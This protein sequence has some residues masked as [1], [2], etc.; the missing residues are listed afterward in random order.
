MNRYPEVDPYEVLGLSRGC[1]AAEIKAA[2]KK[3]AL[4]NH[5]DRAP[6][7]AKDEATAC[8]KRIGEAYTYLSDER[9]RRDYDAFGPGGSGSRSDG[10]EWH[11]DLS[12]KH[13]GTSPEGVPFSFTWES[14]ADSARRARF[15]RNAGRPFGADAFE[16]FEL[17]N[18]MF[19]HEFRSSDPFNSSGLGGGTS[20]RGANID[21]FFQN[22]RMMADTMGFG[23]GAPPP[24]PPHHHHHGHHHSHHHHHHHPGPPHHM[25]GM[26]SSFMTSSSSS[27]NTTSSSSQFGLNGF[28]S[29]S[30]ST[31]TRI[32]NGRQETVTRQV[33]E[34]GNETIHTVSPEGQSV[35]VNGVQQ[36]QHPL[37]GHGVAQAPPA[38]PP[39]PVQMQYQGMGTAQDPIVLDS[40]G[41]QPAA[42]P[43]PT[44]PEPKKTTFGFL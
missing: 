40:D 43:T 24:P 16:P 31:T 36:T 28:S 41:Q 30:Q 33:D 7:D 44:N 20:S 9:K 38:V 6:P 26:Q 12:R 3:Q 35:F 37:L 14:G 18:Q 21:P 2:Y 19:G 10:A 29:T 1:T 11:D 15:G 39:A 27:S 34:R 32:V 42:G 8:F 25:G 5:P 4:K 23:F 13:F 17:F 22:H